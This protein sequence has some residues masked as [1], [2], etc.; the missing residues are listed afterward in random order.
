MPLTVSLA[1]GAGKLIYGGISSLI[2][3]GKKHRAQQEIE[4]LKTPTYQASKPIGDY[5]QT[6]LSRYNTG[7]YNSPLYQMQ[8]QNALRTQAGAISALGDKRS[9]LAG[10]GKIDAL[11]ND[12]LLKAG[13]TAEQQRSQYFSQLGN[14]AQQKAADDKYAFNINQMMPYQK[15]LQLLGMKAGSAAQA[16]DTGISNMWGGANDIGSTYLASKGY[17]TYGGANNGQP[18][19]TPGSGWS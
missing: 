10:I 3:G 2:A 11:T 18:L 17:G 15:K 9:A 8:K 16:Q 14:A 12:N 5:Y 6:A 4:N 19:A 1:L 13:A 7:A